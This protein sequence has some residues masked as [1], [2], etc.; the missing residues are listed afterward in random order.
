MW[1][2]LNGFVAMTEGTVFKLG[3]TALASVLMGVVLFFAAKG[4]APWFDGSAFQRI[5]AMV[6]LVGSGV[7]AFGA[8]ALFLRATS[9]KDL[10]AGF[11][12]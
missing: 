3:R 12:K 5:V 10:K 11:G 7:S 4:L 2:G 1:R 8:L 6:L 9:V